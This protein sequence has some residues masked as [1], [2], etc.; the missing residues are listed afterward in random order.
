LPETWAAGLKPVSVG[1]RIESTASKLTAS[2]R[3]LAAAI[4][5]DYPYA[6]L[7]TIQDLATRAEISAPSISRFVAN[8]GLSGY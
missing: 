7:E 2:E 3:K 4:L 1:G 5:A 8:I 6:G